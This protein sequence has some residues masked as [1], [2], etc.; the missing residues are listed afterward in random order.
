[1]RRFAPVTKMRDPRERKREDLKTVIRSSA[2][3]EA[4]INSQPDVGSFGNQQPES[5][6]WSTAAN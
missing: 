1:M 3:Y 4:R 6:R 2:S 5:R